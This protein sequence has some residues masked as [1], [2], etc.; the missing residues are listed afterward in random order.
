MANLI[1]LDEWSLK[2]V[3]LLDYFEYI[4]EYGVGHFSTLE[5]ELFISTVLHFVSLTLEWLINEKCCDSSTESLYVLENV[6]ERVPGLAPVNNIKKTNF[7]FDVYL[8]IIDLPNVLIVFNY[9]FG[10]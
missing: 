2:Y 8:Q 3:E 1:N 5:D 10:V 7:L 6:L 4:K 9:I